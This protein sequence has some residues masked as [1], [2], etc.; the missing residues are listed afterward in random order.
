MKRNES[1]EM[2][3]TKWNG[4]KLIFGSFS[5]GFKANSW[6]LAAPLLQPQAACAAASAGGRIL[7]GQT[8]THIRGNYAR[9]PYLIFRYISTFVFVETSNGNLPLEQ[10]S[11]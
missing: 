8:Y 1:N 9:S 4:T 3:G 10:I 6:E 5:V 7:G 2:E 11:D